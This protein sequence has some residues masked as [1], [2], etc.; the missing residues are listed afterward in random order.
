[1]F[2]LNEIKESVDYE[3]KLAEGQGG[4]GELPRDFWKTYSAMANTNGGTVVLGVR[5]KK[6]HFEINGIKNIDHIKK[7]LWDT[8]NN[9]SKV[10]YSILKDS[11]VQEEVVDGKSV[12]VI[13][14]PRANRSQRP[15]YIDNNPKTGTYIRRHEGDYQ[16]SEEELKRMMSDSD[17]NHPWDMKPV[18]GYTIKDL[19]ESSVQGYKNYLRAK[20]PTHIFLRSDDFNFLRNIGAITKDSDEITY[21]GLIFFGNYQAL[22]HGL[23]Y[24]SLDYR[25][26]VKD[27]N[28]NDSRWGDRVITDGNWSGNIFDFYFKVAPKLVSGLKIPFKLDSDLSRVD[29]TTTH[30]SVREALI[31]TLI[32]ADHTG[33]VG[34]RILK[35][36]D[37][38]E[39]LNFGTFLFSPEEA[40]RGGKSECRNPTIQKIFALIGIG[41]KAGSGLISILQ[42]WKEN[43]WRRPLLEELFESNETRL[44]LRMVGL[45]P[46]SLIDGLL[47]RFGA[48]FSE[49][50]Q[51]EQ[52]AIITAEN[53]GK[54]TNRRL[55]DLSDIH[56]RDL[57]YLLKGLVDR[58]FL[59][60][61]EDRQSRYYTVNLG[62]SGQGLGGSE[63]SLG[64][65]GQNLGGKSYLERVKMAKRVPPDI[66]EKAILE[67]CCEEKTIDQIATAVGRKDKKELRER[68]ISKLIKSGL[69]ELKF[70]DAVNH[71]HQAYKTKK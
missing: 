43:Q 18:H 28:L 32:H 13:K 60:P 23:P 1:M 69:L 16:C 57:T 24:F 51:T 65:S 71:P 5:E 52:L 4:Q 26:M 63:Q 27:S 6:G 39:F 70:P 58:G 68:F 15:I 2:D 9:K 47:H 67:V 3:F 36:P 33:R 25:E 14:I 11:D 56:G 21:A 40:I 8:I 41:E 38:F 49:L 34:V 29:N 30:Q 19:D 42:T 7:T 45:Y 50:N 35:Y 20:N 64:G 46:D 55:Q 54:V 12:L 62:D 44:E 10:N 22:T 48:K 17:I 66:M 53:E 37:R 31:N 61:F 59:S